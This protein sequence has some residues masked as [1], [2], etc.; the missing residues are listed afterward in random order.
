[1]NSLDFKRKGERTQELRVPTALAKDPSSAPS[2]HTRWLT[3]TSNYRWHCHLLSSGFNKD[4]YTPG[5]HTHHV[6]A[7]THALMHTHT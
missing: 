2:I 4:I 1:M 6:H 3:N 7:H 5:A